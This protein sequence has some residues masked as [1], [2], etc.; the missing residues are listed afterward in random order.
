MARA[1][2]VV[3]FHSFATE[4]WRYASSFRS[5]WLFLAM[6]NPL[7]PLAALPSGRVFISYS[8]I[9]R[10]VAAQVKA[11]LA[12][13]GLSVF[14]AHDDLQVSEEW[15]SRILE[16]LAACDMFVALLSTSFR[17]SDWA[18]QELGYIV[19][20]SSVAIVP[21][22]IDGTTLFG[23]ISHIQG[24]SIPATG[25]DENLLVYPLVPRF[26][27]LMLPVLIRRAADAGSYRGA[28]A[29]MRPLVPFF[30]L[31]NDQEANA[32]AA[33][34]VENG[35]I[36]SA[37]LCRAEYLPRFLE[38]QRANIDTRVLTALEFQIEHNERY[39]PDEA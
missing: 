18:P 31:L 1:S 38:M 7:T 5:P 33:A 17:A 22:S 24:R 26:P 4:L 9:D 13:A 27:R 14:M 8:T 25:P 15:K 39:F 21:L 35:Q 30:G 37:G 32:L 6:A 11:V 19:S 10:A 36:W 3:L 12:R 29:L 23:F 34:A 16:E 20:R 2:P 28:E